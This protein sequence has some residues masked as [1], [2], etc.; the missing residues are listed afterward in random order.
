MGAVSLGN[1]FVRCRARDAPG[2]HPFQDRLAG[3]SRVIYP[4]SCIGLTAFPL[5]QV[6]QMFPIDV[7]DLHTS[8]AVPPLLGV[9]YAVLGSLFVVA[10]N[11]QARQSTAQG[12]EVIRP[13][14]PIPPA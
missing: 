11:L 4:T 2:R 1:V 13:P 5:L 6:Y 3:L 12:E 10:D 7:G 14:P 8:L 9:F